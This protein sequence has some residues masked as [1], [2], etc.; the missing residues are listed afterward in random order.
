[1]SKKSFFQQLFS[2]I[3]LFCIISQIK[4]EIKTIITNGKIV[5]GQVG[6]TPFIG[7]ILIDSSG[8]ISKI[9]QGDDS[10]LIEK[11][12]DA[13][14]YDA[15]NKIIIPGGVDPSVY[16]QY[17]KGEQKIETSD[18]FYTGSIAALCGGTTTFIDMAEPDVTDEDTLKETL[19][20][21]VQ[22][23][24]EKSVL[25]FTFHMGLNYF[26]SFEN[27]TDTSIRQIIN[28][29]GVS[30]FKVDSSSFNSNLNENQKMEIYKILR[31]YG[32]L[33]VS[34]CEEEKLMQSNYNKL[35]SSEKESLKYYTNVYTSEMERD[36]IEKV[37][38]NIK[39]YDFPQGVHIN[40]VSSELSVHAIQEAQKDGIIVTASVTPHHLILTN[41]IY[42]ESNENIDYI[43]SPP[44]RTQKD[45]DSLWKGLNENIIDFVSSDH[46]G[47]TQQQKRG[48]SIKPDYRIYY[49]DDLTVKKNYDTTSEKWWKKDLPFIEVPR[50]VTGIEERLIL[51]Y[52]YGV[53][54][55]KI[56]LEK[57]VQITSTNAAKRFGLYPR[58][59]L[60]EKGSDAD[61][62]VIDPDE[63]T[64]LGVENLH[65][66]CDFCPYEKLKLQGKIQTVFVGG[67]K[68]FDDYK[69]SPK[70]LKRHGTFLK[71]TRY[72]LG[73][74]IN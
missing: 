45:I 42:E 48:K 28:K 65:E 33:I 12:P 18:D 64:V 7:H 67:K 13:E 51:I 24:E 74:I 43:T 38:S 32:G 34:N 59:G 30:S 27:Q 37:I 23:A 50:G 26:V 1:M 17:T 73:H 22:S 36:K 9:Q 44:L 52:H 66:N 58:K 72:F 6:S 68:L 54:E 8:V 62:V 60:L 10:T 49:N 29:S 53:V 20:E 57:F 39:K 5:S 47:F 70:A 14:I 71:R 3:I 41:T 61:I 2:F 63:K 35:S 19:F 25:D 69:L 16:F 15:K 21:K 40:S 11:Y 55:K 46:S 4:T 31:K 56:S